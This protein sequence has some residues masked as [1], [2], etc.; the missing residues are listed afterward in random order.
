MVECVGLELWVED[1]A[2]NANDLE[3]FWLFVAAQSPFSGFD[4]HI[5]VAVTG[6]EMQKVSKCDDWLVEKSKPYPLTQLADV[7]TTFLAMIVPPQRRAFLDSRITIATQVN[8][9]KPVP[10]GALPR[11]WVFCDKKSL[12]VSKKL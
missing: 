4:Q 3:W 8:S 5:V 7:M 6:G 2:L 1:D 12:K 9:P 11:G 10:R